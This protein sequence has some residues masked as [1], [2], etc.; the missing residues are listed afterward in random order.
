MSL[1]LH[2]LQGDS[3]PLAGILVL[4]LGALNV[5]LDR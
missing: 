5:L 2:C 1:T 3:K 4:V